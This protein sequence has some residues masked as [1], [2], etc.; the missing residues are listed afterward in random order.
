MLYRTWEVPLVFDNSPQ[1]PSVH[2]VSTVPSDSTI[3]Y[4]KNDQGA[5][6][7]TDSV[8]ASES[9]SLIGNLAQ[10]DEVGI[11]DPGYFSAGKYPVDYTYIIHP[12]VEYDTVATH[13]NLK[14]AGETHIQYLT[15]RITIPAN[16]IEQVYAYPPSLTT[17]KSGTRY[18]ITGSAAANEI[19]AVEMVGNAQGFSQIKGFRTEGKDIPSQ[20]SSA[21]FWYNVPYFLSILLSQVAKVAVIL[22]PLL[23]IVI[24]NRYGREKEFTVPAYLSTLPS[25][26]LKPWQVNLLLKGGALDF[27]EDGYYA[28]L[29]DLHRRK[30]ISIT[31]KGEGKGIEIRVL[32]TATTDPYELRVLGFVGLVSENGVLDTDSIAALA[33]SARTV[34][35]S[36]EKALQYQRSLTDVTSR[37]DTSLSNQYIVDGRE[38][39]IPFGFVAIVL[40]AIS[41]ILA[42]VMP[43]QS[44]ILFPAEVLWIIVVIQAAIAFAEPSTL[45]GHWKDARYKEKLVWDAFTHFLSDMAVIQ[46]YAPAALSMWGE[47]LV[48]GTAL[49][50]GDKVE[51]AMKT[52]KISIPETGVPLGVMDMNAAFIPLMHFTPPDHG[53]SG[54]GG[55][56]GGGA[57]GRQVFP[58]FWRTGIEI[59]R[60]IKQGSDGGHIRYKPAQTI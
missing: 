60:T 49:G 41:L 5:V 50:V 54:G 47:W 43:M 56:G 13:H 16:N 20:A 25:T 15:I 52:L 34:G 6:Q 36:E 30:I 35:S 59:Y 42:M 45:F 28:T 58:F 26:A 55:F 7:L 37:V 2:F 29:L 24:Y 40:F 22:V 53:G 27:D 11:F 21:S 9:K 8:G 14:L 31:E 3:G 18:I 4:A 44:Y 1:Q 23:F 19:V 51:R 12:P 38:H 46:K 10:T 48:Y 33:K 32:S 17:Q 57:G 39:I